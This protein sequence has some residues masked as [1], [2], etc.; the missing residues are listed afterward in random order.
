MH[1]HGTGQNVPDIAMKFV[2]F[3]VIAVFEPG[4][5]KPGGGEATA[6]HQQ[7]KKYHNIS[8]SHDEY[9]FGNYG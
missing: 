1:Q 8:D 7:K 6:G 3:L 5:S 9:D 2:K 4:F